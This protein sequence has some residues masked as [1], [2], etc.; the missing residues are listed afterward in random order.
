MR[1]GIIGLGNF[2]TAM[3]NLVANNGHE[4][5]GWEYHEAVVDEI[6]TQHT[7]QRFLADVPLHHNLTATTQIETGVQE[8]EAI[9]IAIPTVF[10]HAT[11]QPLRNQIA[12]NAVLINLAKGIDRR[13]GLTAFQ[14]ITNIFPHHRR[15]M[16]SGPSIANEF[17]RGL[18]TVVVAAGEHEHDLWLTA[19]L[20][21]NDHFRVHF[22]DDAIGVELGGILKNI[23]AI[24]LGMFDGQSLQSVNLRAVYLT[25]ALAEMARIGQGFGASIE[26]FLY[27]SGVGDLLATA[28]SEHSHNRRMGELLA[29]GLHIADIQDRMGVLP[30][31]YTTLQSIRAVAEKRR[32]SIPLATGLWQVIQGT[33]STET[34]VQGLIKGFIE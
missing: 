11:L 23:Y 28:L 5:I 29:Q 15:V 3:A 33:L 24:G 27:L 8:R 4:V 22:S 25:A 13:S 2:G 1:V 26:T 9:F 7:N 19:Q 34:F 12:D 31:G 18:P 16:L 32:I 17:A 10:I 30:E 20:L 21:D 6:N 14:I